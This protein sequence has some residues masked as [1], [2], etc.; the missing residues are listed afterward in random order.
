M[1]VTFKDRV[2]SSLQITDDEFSERISRPEFSETQRNH[3]KN[4][5]HGTRRWRYDYIKDA[6]AMRK[7]GEGVRLI[8]IVNVAARDLFGRNRREF[9]SIYTFVSALRTGSKEQRNAAAMGSIFFRVLSDL[10][11]LNF[12]RRFN[13]LCD[14][15][16]HDYY[17]YAFCDLPEIMRLREEKEGDVKQSS[18]EAFMRTR[19]GVPPPEAIFR[20]K[21]SMFME[22]RQSDE[23][24]SYVGAY[25]NWRH[26]MSNDDSKT[27][28]VKAMKTYSRLLVK[29]NEGNATEEM[30][31][32]GRN[33]ISY[34]NPDEFRDRMKEIRNKYGTVAGV[35]GLMIDGV[36]L[37]LSEG[38]SIL[39]RHGKEVVQF[40]LS[41]RTSRARMTFYANGVVDLPFVEA[42]EWSDKRSVGRGTGLLSG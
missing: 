37:F 15:P 34:F 8:D 23:F 29:S 21:S 5:F 22:A 7:E 27:R 24:L 20:W 4:F 38:L 39:T 25:E 35:A 14:R 28:L 26:D 30:V 36:R 13:A 10:Y 3:L 9:L 42:S 17:A 1:G 31:E 6:I 33:S 41:A 11:N 16:G 32:L 18:S 40:G 19:I 12:A 2:V